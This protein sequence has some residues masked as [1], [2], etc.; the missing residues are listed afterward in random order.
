MI[1]LSL[2]LVTLRALNHWNTLEGMIGPHIVT[3]IQLLQHA[4]E[5]INEAHAC[6][7]VKGDTIVMSYMI[8]VV[9]SNEEPHGNELILMWLHKWVP[10]YCHLV[11]KIVISSWLDSSATMGY[12]PKVPK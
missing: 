12:A 1:I 6:C 9:N 5:Y 10:T 7:K 4:Y 8:V 11:T 2:E 3:I